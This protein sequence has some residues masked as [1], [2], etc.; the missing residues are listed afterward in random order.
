VIVMA[1]GKVIS[2]GPM[3]IIR[4]NKEVLSAYLVG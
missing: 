4:K 3:E 1:Q 2:E